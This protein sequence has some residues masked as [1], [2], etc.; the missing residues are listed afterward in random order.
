M[1][2]QFWLVTLSLLSSLA[3]ADDEPA[4]VWVAEGENNRVF[5]L[6]SIHLLREQ[7]HP[8]PAIIDSVYREADRLVMEL[9]MD[10]IDPVA[11]FASLQA[12]GVLQNGQ[13]LRDVMGEAMY[14]EAEAAADDANIPIRMFKTSEPWLAAMTVQEILM[15]RVGFQA[16]K[17]IELTLTAR[18]RADGKAIDGLETVDQQLG[19]L[20]GLSL[21]TQNRW[22]LYSMLEAQRL[23][24]MIDDVVAA[25]RV[26]DL[27]FVEELLLQDMADYPELHE[28]ILID[29]NERW[30]DQI[31]EMLEDDEDIL[32][33]VGAAHLVGDD[34]VP[35][36]LSREGVRIK[37][38]HESVR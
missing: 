29:R 37:Q 23:E 10:D 34:G 12:R 35:D 14:A 9:D 17:G 1:A 26:G 30:V 15:M 36:L 18:A 27:E 22:L 25:W 28:A 7:D 38:L 33:I 16:D 2:K 20:D 5:L 4:M 31:G 19:F 3:F 8:L 32:V 24:I 13:T 6:G 21:D 11:M